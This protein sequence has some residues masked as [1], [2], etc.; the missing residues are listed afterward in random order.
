MLSSDSDGS[1]QKKKCV[2]KERFI[3]VLANRCFLIILFYQLVCF[4]TE[5]D[6]P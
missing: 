2:C 3:A 4:P 1:L 6:S 5:M